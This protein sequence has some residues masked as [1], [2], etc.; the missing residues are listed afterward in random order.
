MPVEVQQPATA[1]TDEMLWQ[2][3]ESTGIMNMDREVFQ[4]VVELTRLGAK[5][6]AIVAMIRLAPKNTLANT[7]A[8]PTTVYFL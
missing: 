3:W 5:P 2:M 1:E 7:E 4:V 6:S 8:D